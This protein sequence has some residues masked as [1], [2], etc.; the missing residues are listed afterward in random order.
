MRAPASAAASAAA[1]PA[2]PAPT[3]TISARRSTFGDLPAIDLA[4]RCGA[5]IGSLIPFSPVIC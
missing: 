5:V 4:S 3:T 1:M 2:G